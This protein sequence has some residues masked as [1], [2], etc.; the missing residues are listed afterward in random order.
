MN[1]NNPHEINEIEVHRTLSILNC[2]ILKGGLY[3]KCAVLYKGD[4]EQ[5]EAFIIEC[6]GQCHTQLVKEYWGDELV[7]EIL[8]YA[9]QKNKKP[10]R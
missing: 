5:A 8:I 9:S 2:I 4:I 3:G 7:N 1:F 6:S 10:S